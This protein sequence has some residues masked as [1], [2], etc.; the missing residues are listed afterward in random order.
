MAKVD[1]AHKNG[2]SLLGSGQGLLGSRCPPHTLPTSRAPLPV[3]PPARQ[4]GQP[5]HRTAQGRFT[6]RTHAAGPSVRGPGLWEGGTG[7]PGEPLLCL[8]TSGE[9]CA[10]FRPTP[11]PGH[12][13]WTGPAPGGLAGAAECGGRRPGCPNPGG[14]VLLWA[15]WVAFR[16]NR[17]LPWSPRGPL[18]PPCPSAAPGTAS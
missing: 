7:R 9:G 18:P 3:L 17:G 5:G 12:S 16:W 6:H 10:S 2:V 8:R 1:R 11:T 15:R 4:S 13:A 14:G